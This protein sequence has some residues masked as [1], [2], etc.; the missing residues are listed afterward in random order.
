MLEIRREIS[1]LSTNSSSSL[2]SFQDEMVAILNKK[3][4][5]SGKKSLRD[6]RDMR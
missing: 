2:T 5:V 6:E 4:Y 3:S 1:T